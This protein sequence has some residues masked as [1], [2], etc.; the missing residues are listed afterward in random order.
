MMATAIQCVATAIQRLW[1][2]YYQLM[3]PLMLATAIQCGT[4]CHAVVIKYYV[5][6]AIYL[7][8]SCYKMHAK[9]P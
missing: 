7:P 3:E 1:V 5:Y 6:I 4:T 9:F 8:C 2:F